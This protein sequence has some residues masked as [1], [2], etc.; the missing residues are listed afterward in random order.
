MNTPSLFPGTMQGQKRQIRVSGC[1]CLWRVAGFC[2]LIQGMASAVAAGQAITIDKQGN[3]TNG[4]SAPVDRRFAQIQPTNV[5]LD[6]SVLD[7]KTRQELIRVLQAE[8]GFAMRPFPRGHKGLTLIANG[9]LSPAGEAYLNM[10]TSIKACVP[11][12]ATA[13][14]SSNVKFEHDKI[15]L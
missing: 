5:P 1:N 12:R 11:S 3:A 13:L 2:L 10:V 4:T 15:I 9:Q 8:Q 14:C 6:Q 7:E